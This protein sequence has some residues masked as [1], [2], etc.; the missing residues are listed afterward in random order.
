MNA[1]RAFLL[2]LLVTSTAYADDAERLISEGVALRRHGRD[3]DAL[4]RF[5]RAHAIAPSARTLGQMGFAEQALGQWL[6]A[7]RD[8]E[9]ARATPRDPWIGKNREAI[10]RA[11]A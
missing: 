8:L 3:A 10:E 5:R 6:P 7:E 11:L 1:V 2:L 9:K 4:E